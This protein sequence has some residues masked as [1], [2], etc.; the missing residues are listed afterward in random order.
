MKIAL[1]SIVLPALLPVALLAGEPGAKLEPELPPDQAVLAKLAAL[2]DNSS[3]VIEGTKVSEASKEALGDF[4]K[5][6]HNMKQTG[7]SSRNFTLKMVWMG[8]RKRAFFCGANHQAPHRFNDAWEFDLAANTW[9]LLYAPDYNDTNY[10]DGKLSEEQKKA[11]VLKDGWL[12][13]TKGGPANPAHTW[14]GLT[15]D[16]EVKAAIWYCVWNK[17]TLGQKLQALGATEEDLYKGPPMWAFYPYEGKWKPLP[18]EKP[19]PT[20]RFAAS[21]EYIPQLK[22]SVLQYQ[23]QSWL[24]DA[25]NM[26]WKDLS[27]KTGGLDLESVVCLDPG[28]N[29]LIGHQGPAKDGKCR[30]R[31]NPLKDGVPQGWDVTVEAAPPEVP[32]GHDSDT[33]MYF[34]SAAKA[35]VL[36]DR[37]GKAVWSYDPDAKKWTKQTPNGPPP[38]FTDKPREGVIGYYDPE[39]N[40]LAMI[41]HGSVW[42]YRLRKAPDSK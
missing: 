32:P 18:S 13:T 40:V 22:G 9:V 10:R 33:L 3:C 19:W 21:L 25:K 41:G 39:R 27:P 17:N 12:C 34:D 14:W 6:W 31:H 42:C 11:L 23:G 4:A 38:P 24:F 35:A 30:T 16:P 8:D 20:N 29:M 36:Y 28:R 15:Y 1:L 2:G 7:P 26:K 37:A 5:G